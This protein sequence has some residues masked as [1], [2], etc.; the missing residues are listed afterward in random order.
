[1]HATLTL[2]YTNI[3]V[4]INNNI[5][6]FGRKVNSTTQNNILIDSA[7][8]QLNDLTH[9]FI[10]PMLADEPPAAKGPTE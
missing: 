6:I 9:H 10:F 5:V 2:H 3:G 8:L 1:M 4:V 7:Y